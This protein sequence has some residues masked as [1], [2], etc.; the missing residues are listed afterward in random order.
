MMTKVN[1]KEIIIYLYWAHDKIEDFNAHDVIF[2][3]N[4]LKHIVCG[5]CNTS[6]EGADET[7][8][9]L[10]DV[11]L[12]E[13]PLAYLLDIKIILSYDPAMIH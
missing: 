8:R 10:E 12:W 9:L 3:A 4:Y 13:L 5:R 2:K 1:L 11:T 6:I 7:C